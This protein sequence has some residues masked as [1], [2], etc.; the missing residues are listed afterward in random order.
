MWCLT[1]VQKIFAALAY[2]NGRFSDCSSFRHE[3]TIVLI[4]EFT[5]SWLYL[6]ERFYVESQAGLALAGGGGAGG[7]EGGWLVQSLATHMTSVRQLVMAFFTIVST[8]SCENTSS[9]WKS[10]MVARRGGLSFVPPLSLQ[11][12]LQN[13]RLAWAKFKI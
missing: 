2:L 7:L 1:A 5:F 11:R 12:P 4:Q 9:A 10:T 13:S 8:S 6:P 3:S